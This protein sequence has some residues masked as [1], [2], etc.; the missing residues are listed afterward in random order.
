MK[1][2]VYFQGFI[3]E[4]QIIYS[5]DIREGTPQAFTRK[6]KNTPLKLMLQMF[7]QRGRSQFS[8]LLNFY[9]DQDKPLD[10]SAVAFYNARMKY[11]PNAIHL[12]MA[13]YFHGL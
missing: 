10:I 5:E 7:S 11:N 2:Q 9:D 12:M 6:R 13:D 4:A 1:T 8:E 3:Q